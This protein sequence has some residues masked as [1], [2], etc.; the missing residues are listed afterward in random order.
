MMVLMPPH[1]T[2]REIET[3]QAAQQARTEL[4]A[5][6]RAFAAYP[7]RWEHEAVLADL[8]AQIANIDRFIES[9]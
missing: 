7:G 4:V 5:T 2:P 1:A 3:L 8:R 6:E 9:K